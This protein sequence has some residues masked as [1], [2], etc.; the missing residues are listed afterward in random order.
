MKEREG[1][2]KGQIGGGRERGGEKEKDRAI[3]R[4]KTER[5]T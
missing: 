4:E 1:R 3:E 2:E 5:P